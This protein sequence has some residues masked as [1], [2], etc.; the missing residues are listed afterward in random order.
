MRRCRTSAAHR[1]TPPPAQTQNALIRFCAA[2]RKQSGEERHAAAVSP[3]FP[4]IRQRHQKNTAALA[5]D[6]ARGASSLPSPCVFFWPSAGERFFPRRLIQ[7]ARQTIRSRE[8]NTLKYPAAAADSK[9]CVLACLIPAGLRKTNGDTVE[10]QY[11]H[12]T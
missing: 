11:L 7:P 8:E 9:A 5:D 2:E 3:P 1:Q 4:S 6:L 12:S 10:A